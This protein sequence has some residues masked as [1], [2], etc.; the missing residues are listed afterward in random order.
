[1]IDGGMRDYSL[2]SSPY[3]VTEV[4]LCDHKDL[5][6]T[7]P[8]KTIPK[9]LIS[10]EEEMSG[11]AIFVGLPMNHRRCAVVCGKEQPPLKRRWLLLS[12]CM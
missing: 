12:L 4:A 3:V 7:S 5:A 8:A 11:F 1:M 6:R 10:S 9:P 2:S